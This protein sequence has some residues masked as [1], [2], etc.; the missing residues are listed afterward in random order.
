MS[1]ERLNA[2]ESELGIKKEKPKES[3]QTNISTPIGVSPSPPKSKSKLEEIEEQLFQSTVT[4][5]SP[6]NPTFKDDFVNDMDPSTPEEVN[7]KYSYAFKLGLAD[8]FRGI[9]QIAGK[10]K[11]EM[12]A[13]QRKLNELMRGEDGGLVTAAYFGGALLDPAGWLIPFGKAKTLYSMAKYGMV[14]GAVAGATGYVDTEEGLV[15]SRGGQALLGAA[16]GG[17][18]APGI[19]ALRNVGVKITGK[20]EVTPVGF[21]RADLTPS[22][23]VERGG[24]TV[25]VKGKAIEEDLSK[26]KVYAEG[27]RTLGLRPEKELGKEPTSV[28]DELVKIFRKK[29]VTVPFPKTQKILD[30]PK[31]GEL[32]AKPQW[33]L[34]KLLKGYEENYGKRFLKVATTG[35]GGTSLVGGLVGFNA[36]PEAPL[37]D[38]NAPLS[39]RFGRAFLGAAG[40]YGL[41][42]GLKKGK[43]K[44]VY[45][46]ETDEPVEISE[47][48]AEV[49][50]RQIIDKYGL[51]KDYKKL[52]GK[53]ILVRDCKNFRGLNNH[54][55]RIAVKSHKDNLKLVKA[56]E[57]IK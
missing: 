47:S 27:E 7:N 5:T 13:E 43:R 30:A 45:G 55:I 19:G 46:A 51:T 25:Q 39:S 34:N 26:G 49:L 9:K 42:K 18:V 8:T 21:K 32:S 28:F 31:Q 16:G 40:G 6:I 14:S 17:I 35:E 11:E 4:D 24:S 33:W 50:G 10:D 41:I 15:K 2:I 52:L 38:A 56:L 53:K 48:Y 23:M 37:F 1:L 29:D 44:T 12:K 54:H 57:A 22:E 3:E 36:D 20:G